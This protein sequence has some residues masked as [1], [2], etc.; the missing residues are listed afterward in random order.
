MREYLN[1]IVCGDNRETILG[2]PD[3]SVNC[4]I[5]SPP[6]YGLRDY[7]MAD[8]LGLESTPEE[9]VANLVAVFREVRRVLRDD[10]TVWLNLGD[11]YWGGKGTNGSSKARKT[12]EDRGYKQ[13]GGTVMMDTRPTDGK[14]P[15]IKPKDLIGI[16]WSVAKALQEPYYMGNIKNAADRAWLAAIIDGEGCLFIHKRKAGQGN[17]QGYERK[18]DTYGA[19]MEV[20]NT[21]ESI[22][23]RCL[24]I[25]GIGSICRVERETSHK[26]RNIPLFRWNVRSN[27]CRDLIK[28]IYPHLIGKQH[29]ARILLG[30]PSSGAYAEKAHASLIELHKGRSACIDFPAPSSLYTPGWYLRQDIVWAKRNP[31]PES[32]RDRCTKSHEYVFLL[33]KSARYYFDQ[34]VIK[35]PAVYGGN[36]ARYARAETAIKSL[37]TSEREGIRPRPFGKAGNNRHGDEGSIYT[38][39][40]TIRNRRSVWTIATQ[41][42]AGAHF[43]VFPP[44][45]IEP[46]ILAGCPEDGIV[47]DPFAGSG[48][49]VLTALRLNRNAI[50]LELN[51]E[52]CGLRQA[53]IDAELA[54][55]KLF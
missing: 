6:Y 36:E 43:A 10:G 42:Y 37:P 5:T 25:T 24:E 21:H 22:V 38:G 17:G 52:Y 39:D 16:P 12:A 35:E 49:T 9:Y 47:L 34:D 33:T 32:V 4:V 20:S 18:N 27:Q 41:P 15:V 40:D 46:M 29:E 50:G 14:H 45:L 1:K 11:S 48:T 55:T 30:C 54:Q 8:Q 44:K 26:M 28:E 53:E 31:M 2:I 13:S 23:K 51:P 3:K 19:G 7:G